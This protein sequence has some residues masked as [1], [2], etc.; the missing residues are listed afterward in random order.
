MPVPSNLATDA[1]AAESAED[2]ASQIPPSDPFVLVWHHQQPGNVHVCEVDGQPRVLPLLSLIRITPGACSVRSARDGERPGQHYQ[3]ML[4]RIRR[5]G[6][7]IVPQDLQI[8]A[9]LLPEGFPPGSYCRAIPAKNKGRAH[10]HPWM[11]ETR[12]FGG[13]SRLREDV[14]AFNRWVAW[15]IDEGHLPP[16]G[17]EHIGDLRAKTAKLRDRARRDTKIPTD[18]REERAAV[19]DRILAALDLAEAK[20][21]PAPPPKPKRAPK[22]KEAEDGQP[23]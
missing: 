8:P 11:V 16:V 3:D 21:E 5:E 19:F 22:T 12:E 10:I 4:S 23:N 18:L 7:F 13:R 6:S 9:E 17:S 2:L 1:F 14:P 20:P 15:L